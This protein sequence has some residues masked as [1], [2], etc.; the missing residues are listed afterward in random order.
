LVE[1]EGLSGR[2]ELKNLKWI[3]KFYSNQAYARLGWSIGFQDFNGDGVDDL[4]LSEPMRD[5]KI[6]PNSGQVYLIKGGSKFPKGEIKDMERISKVYKGKKKSKFGFSIISGINQQG[7]MGIF[8]SS[9]MCN[10]NGRNAG[11]FEF[12]TV[13]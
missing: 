10:E 2:L 7:K 1:W 6:G 9:P 3:T 5:T 4:F 12:H 11:S 8:I 13:E